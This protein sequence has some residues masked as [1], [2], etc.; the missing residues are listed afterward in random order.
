MGMEAVNPGVMAV[1]DAERARLAWQ[2]ARAST[3]YGACVEL[4]ATAGGVAMRDSKDP[5]GPILL[6]TRT[7]FKAF[8]DGARNGDFNGIGQ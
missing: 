2:K 7:E 6:Y 4:A 1:S 8:L 5:D 3:S